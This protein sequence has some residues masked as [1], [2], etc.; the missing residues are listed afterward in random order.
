MRTAGNIIWLILAGIWMAIAYVVAAVVA[1]VGIVT[2]P[3]AIPALKLAGYALW[4]FGR[5][6]VERPGRD[7]ALGTL[8]NILWLLLGGWWL[9]LGHV[10]TGLLLCLTIIG[11]PLGIASF[12]MAG[13]A[14]WPYGRMVV[15]IPPDGPP[16]N[17]LAVPA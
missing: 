16:P 7:V 3:L 4:P 11:I 14:L 2:I 6:V 9:A 5:M 12:K 1:I 10:A 17:A 8:G 13:L 15:P